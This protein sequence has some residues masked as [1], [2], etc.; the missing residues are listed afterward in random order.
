M[1]SI[2]KK[3]V[4]GTAYFYLS[5]SYRESGKVKLIERALGR[6][7][8]SDLSGILEEFISAVVSKR[9]LSIIENIKQKYNVKLEKSPEI[10]KEKNLREFG[11]R[12]TYNTNKIEGSSLTLRETALVINEKDVP[13]NKPTNDINVAQ[14]HMQCYE[15]MIATDAEL[16]MNLVIK[17]HKKLFS[18]HPNNEDLAGI[19]R[20]DQ[21]FISGS[22]FVPPPPKKVVPLLEKLFLWY[23]E[24]KNYLNPALL[25]CIMKFRFVSIHPFL[26]GNGRM[27]RLI[28]N[29]IL[30]KNNYPM[31]NISADIRK[32]YYRALEK[33]QLGFDLKGDEMIF[34]G[35]FFK[36]YVNEWK[37]NPFLSS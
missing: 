2:T 11:I 14:C 17:W 21:I 24:R 7:I 8:P 22:D 31:F 29:C 18:F 6:E 35:W 23:K 5:Y 12:F 15:D 37:K 34:V 4:K 1:V 27:S 36:N 13:I 19:I 10:L 33:A 20:N 28:M 32:T 16:S 30:Y 3:K 25:A 26:D 9:W